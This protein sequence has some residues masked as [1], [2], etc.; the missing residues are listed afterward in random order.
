MTSDDEKNTPILEKDAKII[1]LSGKYHIVMVDTVG[2]IKWNSWAQ[3]SGIRAYM[4]K[5]HIN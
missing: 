1:L 4:I 2:Y 3:F 5:E